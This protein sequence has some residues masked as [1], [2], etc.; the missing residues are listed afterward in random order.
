[1]KNKLLS[2]KHIA[3]LTEAHKEAEAAF[4]KQKESIETIDAEIVALGESMAA[5]TKVKAA[6]E[7]LLK[8]SLGGSTTEAEYKEAISKELE[9][10]KAAVTASEKTIN[11]YKKQL[12]QIEEGTYTDQMYIEYKKVLLDEATKAYEAAKVV[13][14]DA[15]ARLQAVIEKLT[16]ASAE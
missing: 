5:I 3:G 16:K 8:E 2:E 1:M 4:N 10:A 7:E 13:Y 9:V 12:A 11:S 14:E 6:L 15:Q